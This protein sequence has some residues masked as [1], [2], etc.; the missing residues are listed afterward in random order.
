MGIMY[1][2]MASASDCFSLQE[3]L[4]LW[5]KS[6]HIQDDTQCPTKQIKASLHRISIYI[7]CRAVVEMGVCIAF[8]GCGPVSWSVQSFDRCWSNAKWPS[9]IP[10]THVGWPCATSKT[11]TAVGARG[12]ERRR[13][14]RYGV[15]RI[16]VCRSYLPSRS[17]LRRTC[18]RSV[19]VTSRHRRWLSDT[20]DNSWPHSIPR[21][22]PALA[23]FEALLRAALNV[24]D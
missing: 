12:R 22:S 19:R 14:F 6:L 10:Q 8:R 17:L 15:A 13:R 1:S 20:Y 23:S 4:Q 21:L 7:V 24:E 16:Y 9:G 3:Q 11:S 18:Q 5:G 2:M